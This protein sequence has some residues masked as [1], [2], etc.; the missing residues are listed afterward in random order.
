MAITAKPGQKIRV[1]I[2]RAITRDTARK[3]IERLFCKDKSIT[4]PI[5]ARSRNFIPLPK[6]R[7]GC[8]WTKRVNKV[9]A[10][11]IQGKAATIIATPQALRDL[12]SVAT[13]VEIAA[14]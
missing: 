12:A 3:T 9:H 14:A 4:K 2:S 13:F 1:T 10:E 5:D 7:G 11:I 6:R 8:I